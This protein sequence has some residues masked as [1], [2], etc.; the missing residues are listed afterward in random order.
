MK[1]VI[2]MYLLLLGHMTL[3]REVSHVIG[4]PARCPQGYKHDYSGRC[5]KVFFW[6]QTWSRVSTKIKF[7]IQG[8]VGLRVEKAYCCLTFWHQSFTFNS[9]KSTTWCNNFSVYYPDVCLQ[10]NMFRVF[11]RPSSGAQ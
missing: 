3:C 9:N 7:E 2:L 10:L 8:H 1:V 4:A 6:K 11:F 5:R